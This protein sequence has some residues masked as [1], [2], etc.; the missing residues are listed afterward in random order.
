MAFD[1]SYA[2]A[3]ACLVPALT[4]A[5][6][7]RAQGLD[8]ADYESQVWAQSVYETD[9]AAYSLATPMG[10]GSKMESDDSRRARFE[11]DDA[12]VERYGPRLRR[13]PFSSSLAWSIRVCP[14]T[15]LSTA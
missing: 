6:P 13:N 11:G 7:A 10:S 1:A 5:R 12:L 2:L 3:P 8:C 14:R 9:P 15:I 4:A